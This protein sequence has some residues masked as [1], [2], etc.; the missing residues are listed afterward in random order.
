MKINL[1]TGQYM[2]IVVFMLS[3]TAGATAQ[4]TP[5]F[6]PTVTGLIVS[7]ANLIMTVV[8]TPIIFVVTGQSSIVKAVQSM[9]GVDGITVNEKA[10]K[11][12]AQLAVDPAQAKIDVV[13]GAQAAVANTAKS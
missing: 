8:V 1:T 7:I 3:A 2:A 4:L 12:L 13:P 9:P 10:N 5:V 11:T 6:G